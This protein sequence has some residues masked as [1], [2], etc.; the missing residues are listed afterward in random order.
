MTM[1]FVYDY[2]GVVTLESAQGQ[3]CRPKVECLM[4]AYE[5]VCYDILCEFLPD[6][7]RI[8]E[9]GSFKGGSACIVSHGMSRRGKSHVLMCHDLFEPFEVNG[10]THDIERIFDANT[11][12]W[13]ARPIKV[14]GDSKATFSVHPDKSLDYCF[15]DGD[16]SYEGALADITNFMPKLK[17]SGWMLVQDCIGDVANAV[18]DYLQHTDLHHVLHHVLIEPPDGHYITVIHKDSDVLESYYF[19]LQRDIRRVVRSMDMTER[20]DFCDV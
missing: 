5:P 19:R 16:H 17:D 2:D 7:A 10:E 9:V 3:P 4:T 13:D 20:M 14:K 18:R 12:G 1:E 15:I 11:L 8:A 6:G